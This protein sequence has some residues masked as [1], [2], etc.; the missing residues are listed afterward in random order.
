VKTLIHVSL[1]LVFASPL[2]RES[3]GES[4]WQK[5]SPAFG[6]LYTDD[7]ARR[8]G[9]VITVIISE[10]IRGDN[11]EK[12]ELDRNSSSATE[13]QDF[14]LFKTKPTFQQLPKVG[15]D[16]KREFEG[17]GRYT[18]SAS[19]ETRLTAVVREVLANGNLLIEGRREMKI[20]DDVKQIILTGVVRPNDVTPE[21]TVLSEQI[22][23]MKLH[24]E[25]LG[26]VSR[27]R[28]RGWADKILAFVWP[29]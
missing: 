11:S 18:A 19:Y 22:A 27:T 15:Y 5:R 29:F 23:H 12:A 4:L 2:C 21:N 13:V 17:E 16:S 26:P 10:S 9:D 24:N 28:R 1:L 20:G 3:L 7:K 6:M 25:G 8:V 14:Q